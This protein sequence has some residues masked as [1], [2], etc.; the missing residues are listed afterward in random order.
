VT[1]APDAARAALA[2]LGL[3]ATLPGL[4]IGCR[5]VALQDSSPRL[6]EPV[7]PMFPEA[8]E[9]GGAGKPREL[10]ARCPKGGRPISLGSP[11][12]AGAQDDLEIGGAVGYEGGYAV[13]FAR[14]VGAI[15]TAAVALFGPQ[16]TGVARVVELGPVAE[17][18]PA[19][20]LAARSGEVLATA[21]GIPSGRAHGD[22][23]REL[24]VYAVDRDHAAAVASFVKAADDSM[25]SDIA[26]DGRDAFVVWDEALARLGG[27]TPLGAVHGVVRGAPVSRHELK[28]AARDLSPADSDAED[29]RIVADGAGYSVLWIA[30]SSGDAPASD[31]SEVAGESRASGWL[32]RVEIDAQGAARAPARDLTPRGGHVSAYDARMFG[33][34]VGLVVVARDDGEA[35]DG[36]G[37]A[38]LRVRARGGTVDPVQAIDVGGVGRGA[39]AFVDGSPPWLSWVGHEEQLRLLPLDDS[40]SPGG[41]ASSE[42][43]LSEARPLAAWSASAG[44]PAHWLVATP[45]DPSG[46]LRAVECALVRGP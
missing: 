30:R 4:A 22:P 29:P 11:G 9:E 2:A 27:A 32:Q 14:R 20:L 33:N 18:A 36:S 8:W 46:P 25:A 28:V 21:F 41:L 15:R 39:P 40:G 7:A 45:S 13:G 12:D 44:A 10:P 34:G 42:S 26:S 5:K 37:G 1:A 24:K 35:T 6:D 43:A 23:N 16:A 17:D 19:P 38:L 31:A 3:L